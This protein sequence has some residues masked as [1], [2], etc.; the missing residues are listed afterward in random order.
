MK[1]TLMALMLIGSMTSFANVVYH[2]SCEI[3]IPHWPVAKALLR[4]LLERKGYRPDFSSDSPADDS[5]HMVLKL[6]ADSL[7]LF[8]LS[9]P[10][11]HII[12]SESLH[13][14]ISQEEKLMTL[15]RQMPSCI[16][17]FNPFPWPK[18][19]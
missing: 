11:E 9:Y 12:S 15:V 16:I 1:L 2:E 7:H 14:E 4:E 17:E 10:N 6:Q 3:Q 13:E 18:D 8:D 5:R 19:L